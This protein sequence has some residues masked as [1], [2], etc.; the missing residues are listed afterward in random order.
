MAEE[1]RLVKVTQ[2]AALRPVAA[3]YDDL[4]FK[5]FRFEL[6][7][8]RDR[9]CQDELQADESWCIDWGTIE[10][11]LSDEYIL[12]SKMC[13]GKPRAGVCDKEEIQFKGGVKLTV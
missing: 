5:D 9:F 13:A 11:D 1:N 7:E 12:A 4:Y 10:I 3:R 2:P 8:L 6:H